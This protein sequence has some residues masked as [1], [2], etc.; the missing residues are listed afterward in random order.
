MSQSFM[1]RD[2]TILGMTM[3]WIV[4]IGV[5]EGGGIGEER[6]RWEPRTTVRQKG[7]H[8]R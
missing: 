7:S 4:L 5:G 6:G 8:G 1:S 3:V 2:E